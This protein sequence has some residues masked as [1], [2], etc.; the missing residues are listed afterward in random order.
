MTL[1]L[2]IPDYTFPKLEWEQALRLARDL[3]FGALDVGLFAGRSHLRPE[4]LLSHPTQAAA[5][6]TAALRSHEL[7]IA[8]VFGQPAPSF[9]V[10]AVNH[11]DPVERMKATEFFWRFLELAARLNATH[12]TLLPGVHFKEES[13]DDSL[14]RCS[15][16]LAWR[17]ETAAKLGMV[18]AIEPH[19]GSIVSAPMQ[20]R[21]LLELTPALSLTLDYG[22]F[23]CQGIADGDIEPLL[24][25]AS[26]IH[27]RG[28]CTGKLQ[29]AFH[30]NTIDFARIVAV[31]KQSNYSG[32]IAVEYVWSEW[33]GCNQVDN[34]SET[35]LLR[36]FLRSITPV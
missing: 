15:Q 7:E 1:K 5:Q 18:L 10:M 8:D 6:I 36:D 19:L 11:P 34:L 13:Y 3:G 28:G 21:R 17:T 27:A 26:H 31:L 12:I 2:A 9:E 14:S 20:V 23:T 24:A 25:N 4:H 16:E 29:A 35:I 32:H 22:H 33:M 30:E